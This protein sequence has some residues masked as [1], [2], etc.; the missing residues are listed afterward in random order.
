MRV[1][2]FWGEFFLFFCWERTNTVEGIVYVF[3]VIPHPFKDHVF[4]GS[5]EGG[6]FERF[7]GMGAGC[8]L[9]RSIVGA[10]QGF[11]EVSEALYPVFGECTGDDESVGEVCTVL[12]VLVFFESFNYCIN[13]VFV[14]G[15]VE[16]EL[17]L[18]KDAVPGEVLYV[19]Y[20]GD[21][22]IGVF[23]GV[24][25]NGF[26]EGAVYPTGG[27]VADEDQVKH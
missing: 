10:A 1:E 7:S 16:V 19:I 3:G 12:C 15:S 20:P 26:F 9:L 11:G 21:D 4:N 5:A 22:S 14:V 8:F 25:G 27:G 2:G 24:V 17:R 23:V 6:V 13:S 18:T